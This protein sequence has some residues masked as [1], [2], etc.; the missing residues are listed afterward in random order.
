M[1]QNKDKCSDKGCS[2]LKH[3][4][5]KLEIKFDNQ[6]DKT[7]IIFDIIEKGYDDLKSENKKNYEDLK[8]LLEKNNEN[9]G[10]RLGIL[11]IFKGQ[12]S[13]VGTIQLVTFS[14]LLGF[15]TKAV[16]FK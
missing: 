4:V 2:P 14:V 15:L 3:E 8:K 13:V 11:E 7:K 10:K 6:I 12:V 16:F 9:N 1:K 5:E